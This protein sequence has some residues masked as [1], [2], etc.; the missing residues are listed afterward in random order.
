M[1]LSPNDL[2]V[3]IS[4]LVIVIAIKIIMIIAGIMIAIR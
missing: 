1:Y 4:V 3:N 2:S